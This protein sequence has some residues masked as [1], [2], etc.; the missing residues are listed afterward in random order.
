MYGIELAYLMDKK[1]AKAH[2]DLL[3]KV[4]AIAKIA[5]IP[6]VQSQADLLKKI[7]HTD[8]MEHAG[9]NEFEEIRE[10]LRDLIKSHL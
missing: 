10:K 1:Y 2:G 6:E 7:L 5:N 8:Y 3:K 9:I 4:A